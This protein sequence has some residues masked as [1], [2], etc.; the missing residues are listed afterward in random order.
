MLKPTFTGPF[1]KELRLMEKRR[2]DTAKLR[3]IIDLIIREEPL[4]VRC[5]NHILHGNWAGFSE[6]H[7]EGDWLLIYRIDEANRC[8]YFSHTGAHSDFF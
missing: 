7:I 5:G 6:C 1:K 8:V 4:P 3:K 2:K